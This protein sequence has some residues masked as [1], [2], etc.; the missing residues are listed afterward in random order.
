MTL[1]RVISH[2]AAV[3][4][5]PVLYFFAL[6]GSVTQSGPP[7]KW[8]LGHNLHHK[9]ADTAKDPILPTLK[10]LNHMMGVFTAVDENEY[11]KILFTQAHSPVFKDRFLKSLNDYLYLY[12]FGI[13]TL[14]FAI[15][16]MKGLSAFIIGNVGA[17]VATSV[18]TFLAHVKIL[19]TQ[20][21]E[22]PNNS[23]NVYGTFLLF[24]GE[25][26]HNNH[27]ARPKAISNSEHFSQVDIVG[28]ILNL[29]KKTESR[30]SY[31]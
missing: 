21:H 6:L 9:H 31:V 30:R 10:G 23:V 14:V 29:V 8:L 25:E 19:G 5:E 13:Y 1:H 4:P 22:M 2:S 12:T 15:F 17:L 18:I 24:F 20:T 26:I 28:L 3:L 27:H 16:G 7:V 11:T